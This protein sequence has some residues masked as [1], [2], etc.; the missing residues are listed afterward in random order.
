[1]QTN[2]TDTVTHHFYA[3][4]LPDGSYFAGYDPIQGKASFVNNVYD[5][6]LFTNKYEIKLR[7]QE[8]LVEVSISLNANNTVISQ[9]FRPKRRRSN[10]FQR[11]SDA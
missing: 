4:V 8:N 1:M 3:V 9:Q 2:S 10:D 5:A 6:K 7:P 11:K